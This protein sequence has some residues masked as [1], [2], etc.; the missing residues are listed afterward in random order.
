[1][2]AVILFIITMASQQRIIKTVLTWLVPQILANS[3]N[4]SFS[5]NKLLNVSKNNDIMYDWIEVDAHDESMNLEKIEENVH[6]TSEYK[7]LAT[8]TVWQNGY[9]TNVSTGRKLGMSVN[10]NGRLRIKVC[11]PKY[12]LG[13]N[14]EEA[15]IKDTINLFEDLSNMVGFDLSNSIVRS[16]DI[17]HTAITDFTPEAYFPYLCNQTGRV[18][19][20]LDSTLYFG[21]KGGDK[22]ESSKFYNKAK[23]VNKSKTWGGRQQLPVQLEGEELTRFEVGLGRNRTISNVIGGGDVARLGD[24]FKEECVDKLH[25]HWLSSYSNIQKNTEIKMNYTEDMGQKAV[26]EELIF[27][28]LECFG[29]LN[30]ENEL[31]IASKMGAFSNRQAKAA[32]K[33]KLLKAFDE[34]ATPNDLIQELD[35]KM[36]EFEPKW[37]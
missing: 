32:T 20:Q 36:Q 7:T 18:R 16:L 10:N 21:K 13:N 5:H 22:R 35:K 19:W 4:C 12:L 1:M 29:R 28:A 11:P 8:G 27:K 15:S 6:M 25:S 17:T 9:V 3:Y 30:I 31:E 33:K 24:L 26:Q 23:E 34:R 14:A 2:R 37:D